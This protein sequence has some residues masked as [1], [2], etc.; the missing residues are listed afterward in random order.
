MTDEF[1]PIARDLRHRT[2]VKEVKIGKDRTRKVTVKE[3]RK[4]KLYCGL[5][6]LCERC[7]K[8]D[9]PECKLIK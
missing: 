8:G 3:E 4:R 9:Y 6:N 7:D 5:Y 1:C 2:I